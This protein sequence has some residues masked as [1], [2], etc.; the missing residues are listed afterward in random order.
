[1]IIASSIKHDCI[2]VITLALCRSLWAHLESMTYLMDA[3]AHSMQGFPAKVEA[4]EYLTTKMLLG[5][6]EW[7]YAH[8]CSVDSVNSVPKVEMSDETTLF[9]PGN[10]CF[11]T[12]I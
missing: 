5:S 9:V 8:C 3:A 1:M 12:I 7:K 6:P 4:E 2:C 10:K 11:Y